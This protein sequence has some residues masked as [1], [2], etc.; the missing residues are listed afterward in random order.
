MSETDKNARIAAL[1]KIITSKVAHMTPEMQATY[2]FQGGNI[3]VIRPGDTI[4]FDKLLTPEEWQN[5][6]TVKI[7]DV[8]VNN[9]GVSEV[10]KAS[11]GEG[12]PSRIDEH[13]LDGIKAPEVSDEVAGLWQLR[14]PWVPQV[15]L[16]EG[17]DIGGSNLFGRTIPDDPTRAVLDSGVSVETFKDS[18]GILDSECSQLQK[19]LIG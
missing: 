8:P 17:V 3:N 1:E 9:A 10:L 6:L 4:Q 7:E 13:F 14:N 15:D 12:V 5:P 18:L 16:L 11:A 19:R 2:G